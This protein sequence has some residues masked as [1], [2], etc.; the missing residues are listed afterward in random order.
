MTHDDENEIEQVKNS[1]ENN[2]DTLFSENEDAR[3]KRETL[4]DKTSDRYQ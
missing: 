1:K 3:K 4:Q 2:I